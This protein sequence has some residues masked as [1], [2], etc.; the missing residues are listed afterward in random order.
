[1]VPFTLQ[2]IMTSIFM[3][4]DQIEHV[5]SCVTA[6]LD[7]AVRTFTVDRL[8][9]RIGMLLMIVVHILILVIRSY[10]FRPSS[11]ITH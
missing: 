4:R 1:M 6:I 5:I 7:S 3:T 11:Y 9:L 8:Y 10:V 2:A